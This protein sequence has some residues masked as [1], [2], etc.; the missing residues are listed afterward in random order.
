[1]VVHAF[2]PIIQK[3]EIGGSSEFKYSLMEVE[4]H[5]NKFQDSQSRA[6]FSFKR[7]K[8]PQNQTNKKTENQAH[9]LNLT[10]QSYLVEGKKP[11][12]AKLRNTGACEHRNNFLRY[13]WDK[14]LFD[15]T[16]PPQ[17]G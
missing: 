11:T 7:T 4:T 1:M 9:S 5:Y 10:L 6:L 17:E 8:T 13:S 3:T 15:P 12:P 2:K 14:K 16:P